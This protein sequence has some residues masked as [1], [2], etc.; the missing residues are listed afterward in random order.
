[1]NNRWSGRFGLGLK[2]GLAA[3]ALSLLLVFA[4][5][6]AVQAY[7]GEHGEGHHH[8]HEH[9]SPR[10]IDGK[11]KVINETEFDMYVTCDGRNLGK[12]SRCSSEE[13]WVKCGSQYVVADIEGFTTGK[14][15]DIDPRRRHG[16]VTFNP[17]DF[18]RLPVKH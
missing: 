15:V 12:V 17:S 9:R 8:M 10:E 14:D 18:M 11:I 2:Y 7:P 1:M 16:A 13:F 5:G 3:I 6:S 4:A